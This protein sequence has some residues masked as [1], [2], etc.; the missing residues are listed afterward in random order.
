MHG[1]AGLRDLATRVTRW[2]VAPY[3]YAIL[4]AL[5][6]ALAAASLTAAFL[7]GGAAVGPF[8]P[9]VSWAAA[10]P[11]LVFMTIFTGLAEEPGR[12]GFALPHC[13]PT[14]PRSGPVGS[15]AS[16]RVSGTSDRPH[17][18]VTNVVV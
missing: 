13:R 2:R 12:R 18:R 5:P 14:T 7:T 11:F 10:V 1:P 8:A 9:D 16:P 4:V 3:W 15:W 6:L 17:P